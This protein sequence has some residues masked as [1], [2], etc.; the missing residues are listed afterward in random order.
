MIAGGD[1][2]TIGTY[3]NM[4]TKLFDSLS[5]GSFESRFFAYMKAVGLDRITVH[6]SGGG[7]SGGMD[8]MSFHPTTNDALEDSI[9]EHF[10]EALCN[11]I[12]N[13]HGSFADGGGYNVDG[14]VVW[15]V[16]EGTVH[17][18]GTDHYYEYGDEDEESKNERDE[19]FD[20]TLYS[21]SNYKGHGGE[22]DYEL[23]LMFARH[24]KIKL[25]EEL[26]N[27]LLIEATNG[28]EYAIEYVREFK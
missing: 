9:K 19:G 21:S 22:R 18:E 23:V 3:K 24:F 2:N 1:K 27:R 8:Y 25:P 5:L 10:E 20:E 7:D 15:D 13:R 28:N 17:I 14:E 12:Y 26:H 4:N 6:Y 16:T 11:P